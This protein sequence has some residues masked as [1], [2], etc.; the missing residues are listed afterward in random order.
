[1]M[2]NELKP[3]L[4]LSV[5]TIKLHRLDCTS[6]GGATGV[7][8]QFKRRSFLTFW[9]KL[10]SFR[11][12]RFVCDW[13][14]CFSSEWKKFL[15]C[16]CPCPCA[17]VQTQHDFTYLFSIQMYVILVILVHHQDPSASSAIQHCIYLQSQFQFTLLI[18]KE[19]N[20]QT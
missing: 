14:P 7:L 5:I 3:T 4:F 19:N 16:L 8:F 11:D 20:T 10:S 9:P 1:M 12:L 6:R 17:N 15:L 18:K 13:L 2:L